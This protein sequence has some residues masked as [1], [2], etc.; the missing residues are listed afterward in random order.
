MLITKS[1]LAT[2]TN[3]RREN[4]HYWNTLGL[5]KPIQNTEN[6]YFF[7]DSEMDAFKIHLIRFYE[8][9]GYSTNEIINIFNKIDFGKAI[10]DNILN[11]IKNL[12]KLIKD[13]EL[14]FIQTISKY[15]NKETS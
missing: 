2:L 1:K 5:L 8:K 12:E 7:Y 10:K 4:I 9:K 15:I 3:E 6:K 13:Y 14:K 11:N